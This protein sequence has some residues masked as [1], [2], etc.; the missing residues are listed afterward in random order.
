MDNAFFNVSRPA[1]RRVRLREQIPSVEPDIF[2]EIEALL[3]RLPDPTDLNAEERAGMLRATGRIASRV[4]AAQADTAAAADR[5][6]DSR[7]FGAG[8]TGMMVAALTNTDPSAGS[9]VVRTGLDMRRLPAA[10]ASFR[11]GQIGLR[12]LRLLAKAADHLDNFAD[13]ERPLLDIAQGC[14]PGELANLVDVLISQSRPEHLDDE[15]TV[16]HQ[17]RGVSLSLLPNGLYRLDGLLDTVAGQRLRD[18]LQAGMDRPTP[19][20]QRTPKQRRADALDDLVSSATANRRH[21]GVNGLT[22]TID[23]DNLPDRIGATLDS[24]PIGPDTFDL[25][26]CTAVIS[27]VLGTTRGTQFIPL[28]LARTVRTATPA[29]WAAL[30]LR[31]KGCIRCGRAVR[32]CQ[33]HHIV[34]WA[35]GGSSDLD[36]FCLLCSRCH[37]DLHNGHFSIEMVDHVPRISLTRRRPRP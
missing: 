19:E 21:L 28:R 15:E 11:A 26:T 36:N 20:D 31:D 22:I 4:A 12:H 5:S 23:A 14:E 32:Y 34:H 10:G 9:A 27:V 18:A 8:S 17:K 30:T 1:H 25:L 35:A 3:D 29:Q 37:H 16:R 6:D 2:A 24:T 13:L 33:A 7:L